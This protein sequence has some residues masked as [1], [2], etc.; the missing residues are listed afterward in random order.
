MF[1]M[2]RKLFGIPVLP[3]NAVSVAASVLFAYF[4]NSGFVFRTKA[5]GF[6]ERYLIFA[7]G[8]K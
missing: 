4:A 8:R 5:D 6:G 1:F 7:K 2:E 3:A